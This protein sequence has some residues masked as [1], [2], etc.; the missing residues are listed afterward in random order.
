MSA[1]SKPVQPGFA[2]QQVAG[3]IEAQI[4]RGDLKPGD[5]LP[6]E[7][8]MAVSFGVTRSTLREGLRQLESDG[9]V[10]RPSPRRME[11][12]VPQAD[13]LT[14]RAGRAMALMKVTFREL[15]QVTMVTEPLAARLAAQHGTED[16][17]TALQTLHGALVAAEGNATRTIQIDEEFH[18][19]IAEIGRNRVLGLAREPIALL[20]FRGFEQIAP[21]APN[22]Y[23]RQIEAH[24]NVIAAMRDR[25]EDRAEKWARKHIEDF[26]R[27]AQI[28]GLEDKI[29]LN[30]G[31]LS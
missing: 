29:A 10:H 18:T 25:D 1:A 22:F 6:G 20:L 13:Q 30:P 2:Y 26:W 28:A 7:E 27:G 19:L 17:I 16:E 11:V 8:Q 15:T 9:L 24:S 4:L 3:E 12:T 5:Q 21:F 31:A 14:T 23:K